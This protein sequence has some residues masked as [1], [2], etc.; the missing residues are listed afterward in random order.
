MAIPSHRSGHVI[1]MVCDVWLLE[2]NDK[3]I[4]P[5]T[6][7]HSFMLLV[8]AALLGKGEDG[9]IDEADIFHHP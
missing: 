7:P 9:W 3:K 5:K 2:W 1:Y 8:D 6:Q 4:H